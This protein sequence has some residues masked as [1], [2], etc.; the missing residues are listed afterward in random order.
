MITD[1]DS[2]NEIHEHNLQVLYDKAFKKKPNLEVKNDQG[3][4]MVLDEWKDIGF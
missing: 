4:T 3:H 2:S 1:Y